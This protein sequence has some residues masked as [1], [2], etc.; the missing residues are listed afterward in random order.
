MLSKGK[1]FPDID[2]KKI[3]DILAYIVKKTLTH[4]NIIKGQRYKVIGTPEHLKGMGRYHWLNMIG[5]AQ[6]VDVAHDLACINFG[7]C[8]QRAIPPH[9]LEKVEDQTMITDCDKAPTVDSGE[10]L[11]LWYQNLAKQKAEEEQKDM[12][13]QE[14]AKLGQLYRIVKVPP[15]WSKIGNDKQ[16]PALGAIGK[17]INIRKEFGTL[18]LSNGTQ[19]FA[20]F[21]CMEIVIIRV[22]P[23]AGE[24]INLS[25]EELIVKMVQKPLSTLKIIKGLAKMNKDRRLRAFLDKGVIF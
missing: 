19:R 13:T 20:P 21:D 14:T 15:F 16:Y 8:K 24:V 18:K 7:D 9:C 25:D 17:L 22:P 2:L 4:A 6:W 10:G 11:R 12:V 3:S 5:V 23:V 1:L